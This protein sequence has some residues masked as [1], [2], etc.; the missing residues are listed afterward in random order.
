MGKTAMRFDMA[1]LQWIICSMGR[2]TLCHSW[3]GVAVQESVIWT[4]LRG[5]F[6]AMIVLFE[7]VLDPIALTTGHKFE[8]VTNQWL[9]WLRV[10]APVVTEAQVGIGMSR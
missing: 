1:I 4:P 6:G 5:Q 7:L 2:S 10:G 8:A 3:H 9:P